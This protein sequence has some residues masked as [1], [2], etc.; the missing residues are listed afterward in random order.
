MGSIQL[1]ISPIVQAHCV[2]RVRVTPK[3]VTMSQQDRT[4][5]ILQILVESNNHAVRAKPSR[6]RLVCYSSSSSAAG[7]SNASSLRRS[8]RQDGKL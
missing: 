8:P 1:E 4:V 6:L 7:S 2:Q 5:Q 3:I